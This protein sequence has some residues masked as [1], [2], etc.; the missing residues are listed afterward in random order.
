VYAGVDE[1][2]R[3][4]YIVETIRGSR[5]DAERRLAQ[6]ITA[7]DSGQAIATSKARLSEL[8]DAW[9]EACTG[10]L[11]PH[12]RIG[13]R[14]MLRRYLLPTFGSRR[15]DKIKP[16]E[17]ERWY[18]QL[19]EGKTPTSSNPLSPLTVRKIHTIALGDLVDRGAVGLAAG[20]PACPRARSQSHSRSQVAKLSPVGRNL[21][22]CI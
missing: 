16:M 17:L 22:L 19:I 3:R 13:Y 10:H 18:A 2:G 15:I 8:V 12:T 20:E 6:L 5:R 11:S 14:R 7:A 9:W 4:R 1:N 21:L